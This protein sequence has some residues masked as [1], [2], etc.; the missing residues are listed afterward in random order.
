MTFPPA[1]ETLLD[2]ARDLGIL[3]ELLVSELDRARRMASRHPFRARPLEGA[4]PFEK[5][6]RAGP[7][8]VIAE[9]KRASPS[10]GPF[11]STAD[12]A[13]QVAAYRQ[14]GAAACSI[15]AEPTRFLGRPGDFAKAKAKAAG[16]PLLYK[17]FVCTEAHLDEAAA[18]G[19]D[20][21]LLIARVLGEYLPDFAAAARIRGL[22]PLAEV[23]ALA[24]LP[25]VQ[26]AHARMVGWNVRDLSDF[27]VRRAPAALLRDAFPEALL[28]RE[29]GIRTP[30]E[31]Q[32]ALAEGFDALLIGEALMRDPDPARFLASIRVPA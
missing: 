8:P 20:A 23:H 27:S 28:V 19:A 15:L 11:A 7:L 3:R 2:R 18:L 17:G 32:A 14:G 22:E 25:A 5:A 10:L 6:L 21:V 30:E 4:G 31:A 16:L 1:P 13:A 24:E 26:A 9:F 29:S 12:V